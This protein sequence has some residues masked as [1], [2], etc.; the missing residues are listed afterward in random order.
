[1]Q[2]SAQLSWRIWNN[3]FTRRSMSANVI[4]KSDVA[5]TILPRLFCLSGYFT[6]ADVPCM[7]SFKWK[8]LHFIL[9]QQ[10]CKL[11]QLTQD[12]CC[13]F[14]LR[15]FCGLFVRRNQNIQW[16]SPAQS[17]DYRLSCMPQL[18]IKPLAH[19][20]QASTFTT[21]PSGHDSLLSRS[22]SSSSP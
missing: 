14:R 9:Q 13:S 16:K 1:M 3:N 21:E 7:F 12:F 17:G 6:A 20:W 4:V 19:C 22:E 2:P 15:C 8:S 10:K 5:H 11:W 18:E